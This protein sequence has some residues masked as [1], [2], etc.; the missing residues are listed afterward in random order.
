[1]S[2]AIVFICNTAYLVPSVGAALQARRYTSDPSVKIDIFVTDANEEL[3]ARAQKALQGPAI[4]V[5]SVRLDALDSIESKRPRGAQPLPIACFARLC[6]NELL[7]PDIDR[8]LYLDGDVE[9]TA[10][11]DP[12]LNQKIPKG[13]FLAAP[14]VL[15]LIATEWS[16]RATITRS[17]I[18]GLGIQTTDYFNSGVL[19]VDRS[20]W[21][22]IAA[23]ALDYYHANP[24]RCIAND[25]SALNAI[26]GDLR[27][28]LSILWNYQSEFMHVIDPRRWGYQPAI[29]H[30]TGSA[31]PWQTSKLVWGSEFG[32]GFLAGAEL[33]K[34]VGITAPDPKTE[35]IAM[36]EENSKRGRARLNWVY[37]W[38]RLTRGNAIRAAL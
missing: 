2:T 12:L 4:R 30:F 22:A 7:E 19:L 9:I 3:L 29:W 37:P 11:L 24:E 14:D 6:L 36:G 33:M 16:K 13:G 23:K 8:F 20:G 15:C 17:Y 18:H 35:L 31:K 26:A 21:K 38:R 28:R 1:M 27:G 25:Q 10:S 5:R 34:S 32:Q